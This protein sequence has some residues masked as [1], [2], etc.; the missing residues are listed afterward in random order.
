[1][2]KLLIIEDEKWEREGLVDFL[3]WSELKIK[4]IGTAAN[5]V[6]GLK[7]A[8]EYLPEIIITE[9]K[10]PL[11]DGMEFARTIKRV[12][13]CCKII[14]ITGYDDFGYA[15]EAIR[16]GVFDYLLKPIQKD[17]LLDVLKKILVNIK[18]EDDREKHVCMLKHELT[19]SMYENRANFIRNIV[20]GALEAEDDSEPADHLIKSF[21]THRVA[22]AVMRFD[23][24]SYY[25][26]KK[27]GERQ[28]YRRELLRKIREAVSDEGIAVQSD[29]ANNEIIICLLAKD[30]LKNQIYD[31]I[32]RVGQQYCEIKM[33]EFVIG[34]GSTANTLSKLSNSFQQAQIALHHLFYMKGVNILFYEYHVCVIHRLTM[35]LNAQF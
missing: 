5:G 15:E 1:M 14:I 25:K 32:V 23:L 10:M 12:I 28:L 27:E 13:P 21:R 35:L 19:E 8:K 29:A 18:I 31:L 4:I 2:Y 9:I 26:D 33:P 6:Q 7:M 16:L 17:Q 30:D 3:D 24:S 11:M 22:A 20:D 34:I